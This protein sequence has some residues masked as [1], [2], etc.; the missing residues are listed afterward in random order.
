MP[1][2]KS[3]PPPHP[4]SFPG[5]TQILDFIA[6]AGHPLDKREIAR[7]FGI[8]GSDRIQLRLALTALTEDGK[9][10]REGRKYTVPGALARVTVLEV[11]ELNSDGEPVAVPVEW[12]ETR[13]GKSPRVLIPVRQ[14]SK[15]RADSQPPRVGERVLARLEP[16][17]D[18]G[19]AYHATVV[20]KVSG[21]QNRV[22]G[23]F[24][25]AKG[26]GARILPVDKKARRELQ[27]Q[28]GQEGGAQPGE[29]VEA[30]I[31][32]D[33]GQGLVS[34][35][36][37]RRLGDLNDQR[38]I[39]L[40]AIRQHGIPDVFPGR[41]I[42][43]TAEL[44]PFSRANRDD[45]RDVPLI[46][47]DPMDA[48][49][50]D[51][52]VWAEPDTSPGNEGGVRIIVAIA[53]VS[54]YVRSGTALDRE[55]RIRGNSV[56]FPDRVVPMLPERISNDLCSLREGEERPCLACSMIFDGNGI[57]K[58]HRFSR[59][60]MRSA[61][62]L[63]YEEAQAAIDGRPNDKTS[64]LLDPILKPL[65][66]A[67]RILSKGRRKRGP[68]ELDLPERKLILDA[69]GLIERVVTPERLDAHKLVE[70]FMIQANVAAA[71]SLEQRHVPQLYRVH[72]PP[73]AEKIRALG[74]FLHT[75]GIPLD[76]TAALRPTHFNKILAAVVGKDY[77]HVVNEVVLRS[78]AQA[79]YA[80]ENKGH[81]GLNL[82][83]Y[84]HFTSPIRRYADLIIHRGLIKAFGFGPDGLTPEDEAQLDDTADLVSG[85]ER[86]AMAAERE[87]ID[88]LVASHLAS[89]TGS[90]FKGRIAGVVGAGLF[91]KLSDTGAD[92]FVPV[93]SLGTDY[94]VYDEVQHRLVGRRSGE[95]FQ[96][97]DRVEVKL[98]EATPISG[99][100]RLEIVGEGRKGKA[101]VR[102]DVRKPLKRKAG[103]R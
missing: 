81:F 87:T 36:V 93:S 37:I 23:V 24:R 9:L 65:W 42:E 33:R 45:L 55:A 72:E 62:K 32:R 13:D 22:L 19:F 29:L 8:K 47:I 85:A 71:E 77:Q 59:A 61:A 97:G 49:D 39:S 88:R 82:K 67:Y 70:E 7:G 28:P 100:L 10:N 1:R 69:H 46:T 63:S 89:Q 25:V 64:P 14:A 34:A 79:V 43:E 78:Q 90:I 35:R 15:T 98:V 51:D 30:E 50:H 86:R 66:D 20:R 56:Y 102:G 38:N 94:F 76:R 84:S 80:T 44:K 96:L 60:I 41:V 91:V 75:L 48:R 21:D 31:L 27:V 16:S 6:K 83:R 2:K 40:I 11:T 53:D 54:A 92:G 57:K 12:D 52:A 17:R 58:S 101:P 99:G 74:E 26:H 68:L 5:N 103:R 18:R 3:S 95:Q 4:A 73:S